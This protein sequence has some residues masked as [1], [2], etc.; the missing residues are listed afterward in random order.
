MNSD[1]QGPKLRLLDLS[2]LHYRGY[3]LPRRFLRAGIRPPHILVPAGR[4]NTCAAV[5]HARLSDLRLDWLDDAYNA[6][7]STARA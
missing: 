4:R 5:C 3:S 7:S 1:E 6:P 2:D